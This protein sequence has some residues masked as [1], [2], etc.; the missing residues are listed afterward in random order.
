MEQLFQAPVL[1]E[2]KNDQDRVIYVKGTIME[3][4]GHKEAYFMLIPLK[5][6]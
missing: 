1:H 5:N 6:F 2:K 4:G 3:S